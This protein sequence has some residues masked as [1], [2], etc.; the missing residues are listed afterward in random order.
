MLQQLTRKREFPQRVPV[1]TEGP[2]D[3]GAYCPI[4]HPILCSHFF[5]STEWRAVLDG[6]DWLEGRSS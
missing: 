2:T 4:A 3:D 5:S 6:R 1:S